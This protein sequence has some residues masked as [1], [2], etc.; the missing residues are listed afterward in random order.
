LYKAVTRSP[1]LQGVLVYPSV[2]DPQDWFPT[3]EYKRFMEVPEKSLSMRVQGT[4]TILV[5]D[6]VGSVVRSK[7]ETISEDDEKRSL[8]ATQK[9]TDGYIKRVDEAAKAKEQEI[10]EIR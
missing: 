9:M 1:A 2:E 6:G 4:P 10:L 3:A 8:E 7:D 5:V